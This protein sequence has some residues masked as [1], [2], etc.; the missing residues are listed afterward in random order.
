MIVQFYVGED[1]ER[2]LVKL[3]N[4][5]IKHMDQMPKGVQMP[6]VK[7]RSIDDVPVLALTLWSDRYDDFELKR[8][9]QEL[10]DE[11][12]QI[13]DVSQTTLIGGRNREIQVMLDRDKM[14]AFN[15][16]PLMVAQQIQAANQQL[17]SG[18]FNRE[19]TSFSVQTGQFLSSVDDVNNLVVG[20]YHQHL[21][22]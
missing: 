11:I 12:K 22:S 21:I 18:S 16:D 7:T 1:I 19:N 5:I 4:E 13:Y 9:A 10:D 17:Q 20:V 8:V 15:V 3:Y 14:T 2:S 6:L